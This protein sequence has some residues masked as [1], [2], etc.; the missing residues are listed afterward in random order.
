MRRGDTLWMRLS[1]KLA[2]KIEKPRFAGSLSL[3]EAQIRGVRLVKGTAREGKMGCMVCFYFFVD[4][5]DGVIADVRFQAFGP[6][7]LLGAA[8]G[9]CELL[10]RK[11]YDQA[12]NVSADLLD[13]HLRDKA[14]KEAF[15]KE[16]HFSLNLVLQ[17]T[18]EALAGCV[19]IPLPDT[20]V[21]TPLLPPEQEGPYPGWDDLSEQQ[22]IAVVERVIAADIRPYIELDAGGVEIVSLTDGRDLV[23]AYKGACT[24]CYSSVGATLQAIQQILSAKIHPDIRVT[25]DSSFLQSS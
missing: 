7:V 24:T 1:R 8:E 20:Y 22:Q 10:L 15:P 19:D 12:R 11:N 18:D 16:A 21:P 23:I 13:K 6:A 4:E 14:D 17:A 25:P 5:W 3:E 2:E 9:L